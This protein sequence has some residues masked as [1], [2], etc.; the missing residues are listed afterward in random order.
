M[1]EDKYRKIFLEESREHIKHLGDGFVA[2]EKNPE[3]LGGVDEIFRHAHSIKG[4]ASSMGYEGITG[5]SHAMEDLLDLLR[6]RE[7]KVSQKLIDIL[8]DSLDFMEKMVAEVADEGRVVTQ[9]DEKVREMRIFAGEP[10]PPPETTPA[11]EIEGSE[12]LEVTPEEEIPKPVLEEVAKETDEPSPGAGRL[13][14]A[15]DEKKKEF[16]SQFLSTGLSPYYLEVEIARDAMAL[17]ARGYIILSRLA[18]AGVVVGSVPEMEEVKK[19]VSAD[20]IEALLLYGD[21]RPK[22]TRELEGIP[23]VRGIRVEAIRVEWL[24]GE[25]T[26]EASP[27]PPDEP[28]AILPP[29]LK[30]PQTLRVDTSILDHLINIVGELLISQDRLETV[31]SDLALEDLSDELSNLGL[32]VRRFQETIMGVR[33]MPLDLIAG[34]FPRMVRDLSRRAGK[35]VSLEMEGLEIELDRA[36]LEEIGEILLHVLRNSVDHGI[37]EPGERSKAQKP[38]TGE[39]RLKGYREKDWVFIRISDDGRGIDL[40]AVRAKALE[41]NLATEDSLNTM[42][43]DEL[44]MLTTNPGFSTAREVTDVSGRGVGLD[45]VRSKVESLGGTMS[46]ESTP[47][48]GTTVTVR[49]PISLAIVQILVVQTAGQIFGLPVA[50]VHHT[51]EV[52]PGMIKQAGEKEYFKDGRSLVKLQRLSTLL[53]LKRPGP[54]RQSG[55]VVIIEKGRRKLGFM[56]DEL[57]GARDAVIKILGLPLMRIPALTGAT[58]LGDGRPMLILD[59]HRLG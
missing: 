23:E 48:Q 18:R 49:I 46:L 59:A 58:I 52:H 26:P 2:L 10:E 6:K 21:S 20:R 36:I 45:A 38:E 5:L 39:I 40:D 54:I 51:V 35:E 31:T 44:L 53:G 1:I 3:D 16:V 57:V 11:E 14:A 55:P 22:L 17:G 19:G 47:G 9:A 56:V 30:K 34:R 28:E 13:I 33:M 24:T 4:M 15:L 41:M 50:H 43:R 29:R 7:L 12:L 32:L 37:E 8:L 42:N 25:R 27:S